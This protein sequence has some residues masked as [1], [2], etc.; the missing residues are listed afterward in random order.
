MILTVVREKERGARDR[1]KGLEMFQGGFEGRRAGIGMTR[2]SN[3]FPTSRLS[4]ENEAC[5]EPPTPHQRLTNM[6]SRTYQCK[7]ERFST[8]SR[9]PQ[10]LT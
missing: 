8:R 10:H 2:R 7:T 1:E 4:M 6:T 9:S 3:G 5:S